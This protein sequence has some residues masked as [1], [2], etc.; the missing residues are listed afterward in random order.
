MEEGTRAQY[1]DFYFFVYTSTR[2]ERSI[3]F[4]FSQYWKTLTIT[5]KNST[6]N[7]LH[8]ALMFE[9]RFAAFPGLKPPQYL[10]ARQG[11]S[12]FLSYSAATAAADAF[13]TMTMSSFDKQLLESM[14]VA[15]SGRAG[16]FGWLPLRGH[17]L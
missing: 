5:T 13:R 1:V 7:C 14:L 15:I 16:Q 17:L 11:Q 3:K 6:L 8:F 10:L 12:K 4:L 9:S 2:G